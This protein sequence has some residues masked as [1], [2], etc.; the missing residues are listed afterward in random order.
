MCSRREWLRAVGASYNIAD[1][2]I[3]LPNWVNVQQREK[4][5][6]AAAAAVLAETSIAI[7]DGAVL[8]NALKGWSA[9]GGTWH[10]AARHGSVS[11][12]AGWDHP[13]ACTIHHCH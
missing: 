2:Y 5:S 6:V 7:N 3:E 1:V 11:P 12:P 8:C 4:S 9:R 10:G 13:T